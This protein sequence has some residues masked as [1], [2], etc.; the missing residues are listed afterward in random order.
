MGTVRDKIAGIHWAYLGLGFLLLITPYYYFILP[1]H[2][3]MLV[4]I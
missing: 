1:M 3:V 4:D 2:H